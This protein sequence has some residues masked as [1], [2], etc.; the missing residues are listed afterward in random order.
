[1]FPYWLLFSMCAAGAV[2]YEPDARRAVQGGLRLSLAVILI[3]LMIGLRYEVGGDWMS[4]GRMFEITAYYSLWETLASSDPGYM[5]LN[6]IVQRLGLGIWVVNIVCAMLF[7]WGLSRFS[8]RQPNPW[9]AMVVAVP[10]L[11]IVVAMG[12]TR[13]G[14]A[15]GLILAGILT[16]YDRQSLF[17]FA[18]YLMIAA[19]FHKTAVI[20]LPLVALAITRNR[21]VIIGSALLLGAMLFYFFLNPRLDTLVTNYVV[22]DYD[23]EGAMVRVAMNMIPAALFLLFTNRFVVNEFERKLWRNMSWAAFGSFILLFVMESSTVIDRLALYLIPLQLL[24]FSRAPYVLAAKRSARIQIILLII[25]YSA[26]VQFVWLNY[27]KH[28]EVWLPYQIYT[29]QRMYFEG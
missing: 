2:Q 9:L 4:Y 7:M 26:A 6:W 14:V 19:T 27:A 1:L 22:A 11:I 8:R 13:Q 12:Y 10:Y 20:V 28:A 24:V 25:L 16:L 15:I 17:R 23:S 3:V 18:I 29:G 21:F 5:L